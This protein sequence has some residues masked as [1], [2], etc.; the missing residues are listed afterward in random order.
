MEV[1]NSRETRQ[2]ATDWLNSK[3]KDVNEGLT[4]LEK[5][6]YKP[7]VCKIFR[8]NIGRQDIPK[9]L[10]AEMFGYLRYHATKTDAAHTDLTGDETDPSAPVTDKVMTNIEKEL[11]VEIYPAVI[12][13]LL[14]EFRD[15]YVQ[16]SIIHQGLKEVGES[17]DLKST[18]E[19]KRILAVTDAVSH[20]MDI[21]W[22]AME[23][24]KATEALPAE[25]VF[26]TPFDP[27][28][29]VIQEDEKKEDEKKEKAKLELAPDVEGL[30]KQSDN[31]RTKILKA[32]N[33][34]DYQSEKKEDKPNPM[35]EGPKRITVIKRI[36][37]LKAEKEI[38]DLALA[39]AK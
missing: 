21:L 10:Q 34:L 25:E 29:V 27:D 16:R 17:N 20:R 33:R 30:K 18:T 38:I 14:T 15:L 3:T 13:Q 1:D 22:Q 36:D 19:R 23:A 39:N 26:A 24:Y 31:W 7:N 4:I 28:K 6:G 12:K 35:P 2:L 11:A 5:A 37:Q 8:K 9:K 32:Q